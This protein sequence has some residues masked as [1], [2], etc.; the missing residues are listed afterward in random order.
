MISGPSGVGKSQVVR[1]LLDRHTPGLRLSVS[2]T[3]RSPRPGEVDGQDYHF[4]SPADFQKRLAAGDFLEAVEVFGQGHWYGTLT[5]EV[6]PSL[7]RGVWVILEIDVDGAAR[8]VERFPDAVTIFIAPPS[9]AELERRLRDRATESEAAVKVR[10]D[11]A[12]RELARAATYRHQVV[13]ETI[14]QAVDQISAVL[15]ARGLDG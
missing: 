11:A 15:R 5:S 6:S 1:R 7:E 3:T 8:V 9:M 2:A 14:D 10:L 4:L 12:R 13:N